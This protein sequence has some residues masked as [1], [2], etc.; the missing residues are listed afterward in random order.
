MK[1]LERLVETLVRLP[2]ET[3]WLEF[4]HN[5][6]IPE[7]IG[8]RISGLANAATLD[9]RTLIIAAIIICLHEVNQIVSLGLFSIF[10]LDGVG[11]SLNNFT[12]AFGVNNLREILCDVSIDTGRNDSG[13]WLN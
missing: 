11:I 4:K 8:E 1:N 5:N 3:P 2:N 10:D 6:Y 13:F 9:D 7:M 12:G